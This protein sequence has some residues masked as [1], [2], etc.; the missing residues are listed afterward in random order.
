MTFVS[1]MSKEILSDRLVGVT[2]SGD[3]VDL[4]VPIPYYCHT[5]GY[6]PIL[7]RDNADLERIRYI[8]ERYNQAV[9][10]ALDHFPHAEN[11]LIIDSY[12]VGFKN[13]IERLIEDY[14]KLRRVMLGG[15][16]LCW[17]RS[18]LTPSIVYYD[19]LSVPEVRKKR[20]P[21]VESLPTGLMESSGV[22]AVWVF[23]RLVWERSNGF[24]IDTP[25][26]NTNCLNT[27]GYRI[28]LDWDA[29]F[30]RTH[31]TNPS[32]LDEHYPLTARLYKSIA[33]NTRIRTRLGLKKRDKK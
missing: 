19:T 18:R 30:W 7:H 33:M 9:S 28:M 22:G 13:S 29:R 21:K 25:L 2:V 14:G 4:S 32:I 15:A 11:V 20:W 16:I 27:S 23:P 6:R 5:E 24:R 8:N 12:Y 26:A 17:D 3:K 1:K 31:E 10:I